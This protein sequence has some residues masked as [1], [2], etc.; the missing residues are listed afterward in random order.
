[1]L[2]IKFEKIEKR[3]HYYAIYCITSHKNEKNGVNE[4]N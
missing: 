4:F 3:Y 2:V 1:M